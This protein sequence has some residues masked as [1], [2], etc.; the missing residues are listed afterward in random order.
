[1][2]NYMDVFKKNFYRNKGQKLLLSGRPEKAYP[3]LEL[4]LMMDIEPH[5]MY[6]L[7]LAFLAMQK[8]E[9][10]EMFLKKIV[11]QA[12]DNALAVLTLSDLYTQRRDW[13][14]ALEIMDRLCKAFPANPVYKKYM[15]VISDPKRRESYIKAKE[16]LNI[17]QKEILS[18]DIDTAF[19][20]LK[21][22]VKLDPENPYIHNNLGSI[23]LRAKNEPKKAFEHY[24]KAYKLNPNS[25]TFKENLE[26]TRRLIAD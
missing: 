20:K 14:K 16:L 22:A 2:F 5:N 19:N 12:P 18:G 9:E 6:N 8:Y 7:A 26:K 25:K 4:A 23:Y 3:Y 1:M 24:H 13:D 21:Q 15:Q 11:A 10:A 17:A